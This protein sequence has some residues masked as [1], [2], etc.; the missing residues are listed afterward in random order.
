MCFSAS[1]SSEL[2][3]NC[4]VY[5]STSPYIC[6]TCKDDYQTASVEVA[7]ASAILKCLNENTEL[8]PSCTK[9]TQATSTSTYYCKTGSCD[10]ATQIQ[11]DTLTSTNPN[12]LACTTSTVFP[13]GNFQGGC[14]Y[15]QRPTATST[16]LKCSSCVSGSGDYCKIA[17][18]D[19][20]CT[21]APD[22]LTY[23]S[24]A[25]VSGTE[26]CAIDGFIASCN[27]YESI[28]ARVLGKCIGCDSTSSNPVVANLSATESKC[29]A[30]S[31][32]NCKYYNADGTCQ[33]CNPGTVGTTVNLVESS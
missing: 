17:T 12:A 32:V 5:Q 31:I 23:G 3:P 8:I 30:T 16:V 4:D 26:T 9:Y 25:N 20:T 15:Y 2:D 14:N 22:T 18:G 11:I 21:G 24:P 7:G 1:A 27:N 28:N 33:K 6:S 19:T 10:S 13:A 29:I